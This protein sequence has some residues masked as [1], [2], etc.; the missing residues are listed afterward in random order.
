MTGY[1]QGVFLIEVTKICGSL[2]A[3]VDDADEVMITDKS[4]L[5]RLLFLGV[6]T[7]SLVDI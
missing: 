1:N 3:G 5:T 7:G 6:T 4:S 2:H